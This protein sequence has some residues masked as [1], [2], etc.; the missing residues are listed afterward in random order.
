MC[1]LTTVEPP[2]STHS[3]LDQAV[4]Q[5]GNDC[6]FSMANFPSHRIIFWSKTCLT[7]SWTGFDWVEP[8]RICLSNKT[9]NT[10]YNR[11]WILGWMKTLRRNWTSNG[12][13]KQR[14]NIYN[15][16]IWRSPRAKRFFSIRPPCASSSLFC[17][18]PIQ[19]LAEPV[20][21]GWSYGKYVS[22]IKQ[23]IQIV[24]IVISI[25]STWRSSQPQNFSFSV[26]GCFLMREGS[27]SFWTGNGWRHN[28]Y[29]APIKPINTI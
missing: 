12:W 13:K 9:D 19:S 26:Y 10:E 4:L 8:W 24:S 29:A 15:R 16:P 2:E 20:I 28:E 3:L 1:L 14:R 5:H 21:S 6:Y 7:S 22:P 11:S 18:K 27:S 23:C 17:Q 25:V